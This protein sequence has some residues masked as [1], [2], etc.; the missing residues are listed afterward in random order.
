MRIIVS[1]TKR[2][3]EDTD[4]FDCR[5]LPQF[6]EKTQRIYIRL[7][8]MSGE[9]LKQLWKCNDSIVL[10]NKE[11]LERMN[12]QERLTPAILAYDG[13]QY[14]CLAPD[15]FTTQE[16]EYVQQHLR[17]L[18]GF[19]GILRP[20]DG[21][22]P[23][24]LAMKTK[25]EID[26][27]KNLYEFWGSSI[28]EKLFSETDCVI[29]LTSKEYSISVSRQMSKLRQQNKISESASMITCVF[30]KKMNGKIVQRESRNDRDRAEMVR[31]LAEIQA[32]NP[33]QIKQF[34]R[35]GYHFS[36]EDSTDTKYV[37][38]KE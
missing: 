38:L 19:Y 5:A 27:K 8:Q 35:L 3:K 16:L 15:V 12:L 18:S 13:L 1:P 31:Y 33:E 20:L 2:M 4:S 22:T 17:I 21:V 10:Q 9:Q 34:C 30:G 37:F 14:Q 26:G 23:H 6:L 24:H 25:L 28:A 7:A 29:N 36:K 32:E 11:R